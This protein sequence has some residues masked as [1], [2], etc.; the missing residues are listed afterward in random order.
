MRTVQGKVSLLCFGE[1]FLQGFDSLSWDYENDQHVAISV[2]CPIMHELRNLTV[3]YKVDRR[4]DEHIQSKYRVRQGR[5]R[6]LPPSPGLRLLCHVRGKGVTVVD[7]TGDMWKQLWISRK[8]V[9]SNF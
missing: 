8:M 7:M 1:A 4:K 5:M 6:F 9:L 3:G 2:D